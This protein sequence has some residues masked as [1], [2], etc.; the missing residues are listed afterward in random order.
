M[1]NFTFWKNLHY[2]AVTFVAAMAALFLSMR[3]DLQQPYWAMLTAY[4]V[5]QPLPAAVRSKAIHRL[6]GTLIGGAVAVFVVPRLVNAPLLLSLVLACWVGACLTVSLL[7]RTPRSYLSMLAGYTAAIIAFSNINHPELIFEIAVA[8]VEEITIG[9]MCAT[10]V[11]SL[12]FPKPIGGVIRQKAHAALSEANR[13]A[14]DILGQQQTALSLDKAKLAAAATEIHLLATHLP[15]DPSVYRETSAVFRALHDRLLRVLPVLSSLAEQMVR[16]AEFQPNWPEQFTRLRDEVMTWLAQGGQ[17]PS[18]EIPELDLSTL[19]QWQS[20]YFQ[21]LIHKLQETIGLLQE[22]Y[23]LEMYLRTPEAPIPA[24]LTEIVDRAKKIPLH[25]DVGMALVSGMSAMLAISLAC[26]TWIQ[27][28]WAEGNSSAVITAILCCL[29]ATLDDPVPAMKTFGYSVALALSLAFIYQFFIFPRVNS[30]PLLVLVLAPALLTLGTIAC[31]PRYAMFSMIVLLNF[32]NVMSIQSHFATDFSVFMNVNL[33]LFFGVLLTVY[34]AKSLRSI[35]LNAMVSRMS[36]KI[37]ETMLKML[38]PQTSGDI[39]SLRAMIID[40]IGLLAPRIARLNPQAIEVVESVNQFRGVLLLS[41]LMV[42]LNRA[43]DTTAGDIQS[44]KNWVKQYLLKLQGKDSGAEM[45]IEQ[46]DL[47]L[48]GFLV[49]QSQVDMV[50]LLVNLRR[51]I[52]PAA[53]AIQLSGRDM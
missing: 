19:N 53:P 28:G 49:Q 38:S 1:L 10:V 48:H 23:A 24:A 39:E 44:L 31:Y 2:S 26:F 52:F 3:I 42:L 34:V 5:S 29:F 7:D 25:R 16:V 15:F 14:I 36:A 21:A 50:V 33:S 45:N 12:W 32:C 35:S 27:L 43:S 40:Q 8:R 18:P 22:A 30:Y 37:L 51:L 47:M 17:G 11:H 4:I 9:I 41:E 13:W 6:V 46:F 20:I